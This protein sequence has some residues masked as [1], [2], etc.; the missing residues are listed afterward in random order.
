MLGRQLIVA[1]D[2]FDF[3]YLQRSCFDVRLS[4]FI[5]ASIP[6]SGGRRRRHW[7]G[8]TEIVGVHDPAHVP[9]LRNDATA[10]IMNPPH[11]WPPRTNLLLGPESRRAGP[12]QALLADAGRLRD[13]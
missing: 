4:A 3:V 9:K 2:L 1:N 12:A 5:G 13:D 6:R 7:L 10:H 8:A 11:D